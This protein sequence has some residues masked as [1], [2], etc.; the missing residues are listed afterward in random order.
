ML[1][2]LGSATHAFP[3]QLRL[4]HKWLIPTTGGDRINKLLVF[5][6]ALTN[7]SQIPPKIQ[8]CQVS[9][10]DRADN[11]SPDFEQAAKLLRSKLTCPILPLLIPAHSV[12]K[13][14][15]E[16]TQRKKYGL[17]V[18]GASNEGLLQNAVRG[19]IPEAIARYANSTV[20]IFRSS[21]K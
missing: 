5:L 12:S 10:P 19:N 13:A 8:L 15:I 11:F 21:L 7:L 20:I 1:I 3:Q 2:K 16:L 4:R 18:L 9:Y 14:I 17:I 6:P